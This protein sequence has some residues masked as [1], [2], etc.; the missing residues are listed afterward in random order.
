M[1]SENGTNDDRDPIAAQALD[2]GE[3]AS[4]ISVPPKLVRHLGGWTVQRGLESG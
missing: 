3:H 4:K 1:L 2:S